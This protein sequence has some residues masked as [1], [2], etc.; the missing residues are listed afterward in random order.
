MESLPFIHYAKT[1][2]VISKKGLPA[3]GDEPA[4]P[5]QNN[6]V[7]TGDLAYQQKTSGKIGGGS[8]NKHDFCTHCPCTSA[9]HDLLSFVT[10]D[11]RCE[12]C[13]RN[14]CETCAHPNVNDTTELRAKGIK[15]LDLLLEDF[16]W[17]G[18]RDLSS[19]SYHDM[20]P[21]KD[22]QC[23]LGYDENFEKVMKMRNLSG[24]EIGNEISDSDEAHLYDFVRHL[25]HTEEESTVLVN[26]KIKVDPNVVEKLTRLPS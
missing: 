3:D 17:T 21:K 18:G 23:F 2:V 12:R 4:F 25:L 9:Q 11:R 10:G 19:L 22:V 13:V 15:L 14:E 5:P 7:G 6:M 1:M 8:N 26:T 24:T 16:A 20:M